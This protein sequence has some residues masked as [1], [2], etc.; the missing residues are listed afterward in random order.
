MVG[1]VKSNIGHTEACAA[2]AS[3]IKTIECMERGQI[4][5][6]MHFTNPNPK[7]DFHNVQ[8]PT[9]MLDWPKGNV[10][11]AAVNTFGAGGT[12]GHAVLEHYP[13]VLSADY[14]GTRP[15]LYKVSANDPD[16]LKRL[17]RK[18]AGYVQT[19]LPNIHDL[20][21][22]LLSRRSTLRTALF[23]TASSHKELI[24]KLK[25]DNLK[26]SE[27]SKSIDK[28]TVFLFTGQGAQW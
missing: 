7:I 9:E 4:P 11:R 26:I 24:T 14:A 8:I 17:A 19:K 1:S 22:T 21:Y 13:R 27:V 25:A 12:N 5:P 18:Y 28:K 6:Q 23:L 20:A 15:W 16:T 2:L 10:R 3:L